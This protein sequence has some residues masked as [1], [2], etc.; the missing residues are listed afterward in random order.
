VTFSTK[1]DGG[2]PVAGSPRRS[3]VAAD[4]EVP[5]RQKARHRSQR[6]GPR[7]HSSRISTRETGKS[8]GVG[9]SKS[10]GGR[11]GRPP[12]TRR[13]LPLAKADVIVRRHLQTAGARDPP[14]KAASSPRGRKGV[15][16]IIRA[17]YDEPNGETP[18][19]DGG[20]LITEI[21][22]ARRPR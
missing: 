13:C 5:A 15:C 7:G 4:D 8:C 17:V 22:A 10:R 12:H 11:G 6:G 19:F 16:S 18:L 1:V 9:R 20:L 2:F 3:G 14:R 21:E